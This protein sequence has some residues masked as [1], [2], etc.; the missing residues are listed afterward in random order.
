VLAAAALG[1]ENALSRSRLWSSWGSDAATSAAA[2]A[3]CVVHSSQ[4]TVHAP[5]TSCERR[6]AS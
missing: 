3:P 6:S 1:T 4:S 5:R 2:A